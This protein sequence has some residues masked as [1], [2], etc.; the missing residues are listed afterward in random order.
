MIIKSDI[1]DKPMIKLYT[2][3][4]VCATLR[5]SSRTIWRMIEAG[6]ISYTHR[7]GCHIFFSQEEIEKYIKSM[8]VSISD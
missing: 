1:K 6:E 8:E 7:R 2:L 3:K 5:C 4:E